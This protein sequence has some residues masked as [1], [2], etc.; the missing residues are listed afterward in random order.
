MPN[1]R[2]IDIDDEID[3]LLAEILYKKILTQANKT[4]FFTFYIKQY[5][6]KLYNTFNTLIVLGK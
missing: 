5:K 6:F 2:S 3:F 4:I 1:N